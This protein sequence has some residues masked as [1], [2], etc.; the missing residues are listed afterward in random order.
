MRLQSVIGSVFDKTNLS[1][2]G[3]RLEMRAPLNL[4]D[5]M[6]E[7]LDFGFRRF[8]MIRDHYRT[9]ETESDDLAFVELKFTNVSSPRPLCLAALELRHYDD[10]ENFVPVSSQEDLFKSY[11]YQNESI[12]QR[13]C[14]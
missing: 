14:F 10:L 2:V 7:L 1:S 5:V 3:I 6:I 9:A 11:I 13:F 12:V 8:D 4:N